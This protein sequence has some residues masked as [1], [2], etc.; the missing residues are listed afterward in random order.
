MSRGCPAFRATQWA[1]WNLV[2]IPTGWSC[3]VMLCVSRVPATPTYFP[4]LKLLVPGGSLASLANTLCP[5]VLPSG[6]TGTSNRA[7]LER[8]SKKCRAA[9]TQ[10]CSSAVTRQVLLRVRPALSHRGPNSAVGAIRSGGY[11]N[12][13]EWYVVIRS[14]AADCSVIRGPNHV[15]PGNSTHRGTDPEVTM[16]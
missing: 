13:L 7:K 9:H 11:W 3:T 14:D 15:A 16:Q 6:P 1:E 4:A 10:R 2:F 8:L 12:E 5:K